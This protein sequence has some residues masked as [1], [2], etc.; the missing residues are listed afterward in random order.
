[1]T[2]LMPDSM[3]S[4]D[5]GMPEFQNSAMTSRGHGQEHSTERE[6]LVHNYS[7]AAPKT[8]ERSVITTT[9]KTSPTVTMMQKTMQN[10]MTL[11]FDGDVSL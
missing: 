11:N 10:T 5:T 4:E 6:G 7:F 2:N 8:T 1:M 9:N 3:L